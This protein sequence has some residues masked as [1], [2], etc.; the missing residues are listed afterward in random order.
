MIAMNSFQNI[1]V[2]INY[3]DSSRRA[4]LQAHRIAGE[5]G[6]AL[7]A[8]HVFPPV[9]INEFANFYA[10]ERL[11]LMEDAR[12]SLKEFVSETLGEHHG[13]TCEVGEGI[14]HHELVV[15]AEE[16]KADLIVLGASDPAR[17]PR[18]TGQFA[19]KCL[20]F[21]T[22]PVLL[23]NSRT[24]GAFA[25]IS[26]CVDFSESTRP[27]MEM[28]ARM[29]GEV[30]REIEIVHAL[31]PPWLRRGKIRYHPEVRV[32]EEKKRQFQEILDGQLHATAKSVS[33]LFETKP[34]CISLESEDPDDALLTHLDESRTDLA[35]LGRSGKGA[36]GLK[37]DL[38]GGT[39]ETLIRHATCSV[40]VVPI[41]R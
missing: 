4:L 34:T 3:T 18:K 7:Q 11:G 40:L 21:A 35:V 15:R 8:L 28:V 1:L 25:K 5:S 23:V 24:E 39:A 37:T 22:T 16:T 32:D 27:V 6:A 29:P 14:P 38:L 33:D 9:E 20:R 19:V 31:C 36:K 41:V 30:N 26:A 13:V 12:N 10:L 2:G 17:K